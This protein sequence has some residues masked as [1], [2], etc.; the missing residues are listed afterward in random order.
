MTKQV[1]RVD[2]SIFGSNG[3]SSQLSDHLIEKLKQ[4]GPVNIVKRDLNAEP[5][6][7]LTLDIVNAIGTAENERDTQQREWA[8]KA[9]QVIAEVKQ[10]DII[11]L[12]AP[13]YNF[14]VPS[15]VKAWMDYLAR[16]GET[17]RYTEHGPEGLLTNKKVF[18]VSSRGG[19]HFG[20]ASDTQTDFVNTFLNFVGLSDIEWIYAEGLAMSDHKDQSIT[21]AKQRIQALSV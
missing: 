6:P 12:T 4:D 5:L 2:S 10:A 18:V 14:S 15:S 1:L 9:D 17:F 16:A 3:H 13:M 21:E 8:E 7:H 20:K 19:L 11:I